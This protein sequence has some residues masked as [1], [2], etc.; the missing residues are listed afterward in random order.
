[1]LYL[2]WNNIEEFGLNSMLSHK[3]YKEKIEENSE[4]LINFTQKWPNE[5]LVKFL[6]KLFEPPKEV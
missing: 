6:L 3:N 4:F 1:M 5:R 2:L